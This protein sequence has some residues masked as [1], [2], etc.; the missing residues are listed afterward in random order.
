[1]R[2]VYDAIMKIAADTS[3]TI[4]KER[5]KP[6]IP[7]KVKGNSVKNKM[8]AELSKSIGPAN[9]SGGVE[10]SPGG[11]EAFLKGSVGGK[12][13]KA[14]GAVTGEVSREMVP[15]KKPS[16][17]AKFGVRGGIGPIS[18]KLERKYKGLSSPGGPKKSVAA[19]ILANLDKHTSLGV[20]GAVNDP[21]PGKRLRWTASGLL[22]RTF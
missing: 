20:H 22:T 6:A 9:V 13:G 1:M 16:T 18:A 15:F 5:Q 2:Y 8:S 19:A 21:L 10:A 17:D 7:L 12:R 4:S 11:A 3:P 14:R